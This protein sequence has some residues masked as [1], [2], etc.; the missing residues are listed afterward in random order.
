MANIIR[1]HYNIHFH[2]INFRFIYNITSLYVIWENENTCFTSTY[3]KCKKY[4]VSESIK[5]DFRLQSTNLNRFVVNYLCFIFT[6]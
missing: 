5:L 2:N 1:F 4:K 3:K 6:R